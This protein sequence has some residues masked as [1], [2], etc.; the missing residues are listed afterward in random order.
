MVVVFL[1]G[2]MPC[3]D[4]STKGEGFEGRSREGTDE[5]PR[6]RKCEEVCSFGRG[7]EGGKTILLMSLS[8]PHLLYFSCPTLVSLSLIVSVFPVMSNTFQH[9]YQCLCAPVGTVHTSPR[10]QSP[11]T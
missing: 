8:C 1:S 6:E 10:G 2:L 4:L 7:T 3:Q 11:V 9:F 5:P